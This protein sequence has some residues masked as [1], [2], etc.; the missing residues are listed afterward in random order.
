VQLE[1]FQSLMLCTLALEVLGR[2]DEARASDQEGVRRAERLLE[3]DPTN[4]RALSLGANSLWRLG[5]HERALDWCARA[6]AIGGHDPAVVTNV[7][8]VYAKAG[9]KEDA[10]AC[11]ARTFARGIGK[12]DWIEKDPDYDSLRDD[13]R[14]QALL[15]GLS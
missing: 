5:E 11:L 1:D 13:P 8:C 3:L 15:A 14:F 4:L 2:H 6:L 7:G 12:R 10:L 9:R